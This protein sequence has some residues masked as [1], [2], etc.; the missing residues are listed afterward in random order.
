MGKDLREKGR[1]ME[2]GKDGS[3]TTQGKRGGGRI[4]RQGEGFPEAPILLLGERGRK[5]GR[6]RREKKKRK[7]KKRE[8]EFNDG[9]DGVEED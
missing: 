9:G 7:R 8:C 2:E 5:I 1:V 3:S 4:C 6:K